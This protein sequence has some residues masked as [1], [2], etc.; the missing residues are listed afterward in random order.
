MKFKKKN[1]E[2][3][4]KIVKLVFIILLLLFIYFYFFDNFI[5]NK[6]T[7]ISNDQIEKKL[8]SSSDEYIKEI[9]YLIGKNEVI[10]EGV[11]VKNG[12]KEKF[13]F[14]T[15]K[16]EFIPIRKKLETSGKNGTSPEIN[17]YTK[18]NT[19]FDFLNLLIPLLIIYFYFIKI[20]NVNQKIAHNKSN[21]YFKDIAGCE[22]EK[23]EMKKI[24]SYL[25]SPEKFVK[26]GVKL[27]KGILFSGHPGTGKTLLAKAIAN[28]AGVPFYYS[29]GSEFDEMLAGLGA[30]RV[31]KLFKNARQNSP[32]VIFIDEIDSIGRARENNASYSDQTLNQFLVEMDGFKENSGIIVIAATNRVDVLDKALIRSGR[33]DKIIFIPLPNKKDREK[34]FKIHSKN[35][36]ISSDVNFEKL[37]LRTTGLSGADIENIM[38][39]A[40][41]LAI[42]QNQTEINLANIEEAIDRRILGLAKK[43]YVISTKEKKIIAYHE[44]GHAVIGLKLSGSDKVQKISIIPRGQTGGYVAMNS[45]HDKLIFTKDDL[46]ARIVGYLGGRASEEIFIGNMS[47][48]AS[49]DIEMATNL[50]RAMVI[51]YG[52]SSLGP[53]KYEKNYFSLI[54]KPYDFSENTICKIDQEIKSIIDEAYKKAKL[55]ISKNKKLVDLIAKTLLEKEVIT[56]EQIENLSK[57]KNVENR[58]CA[59]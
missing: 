57:Q 7:K 54:E 4:K 25:K 30:S 19:I 46:F 21:I 28:E 58:K 32:C 18:K 51:N 16:K 33:F 22:E 36:K 5:L 15:S 14:I 35:K 11:S 31:R 40:A 34:I 43:S 8:T 20:K 44:S 10:Y 39:E 50:A 47:S 26:F 41:F 1:I 53:I 38:N 9:K 13:E 29:S 12:V 52:M 56:S 27:P 45:E 59:N 49:N 48:G 6:K 23:K 37:S 24:V 2:T 55:I 3:I 42:S 17:Q